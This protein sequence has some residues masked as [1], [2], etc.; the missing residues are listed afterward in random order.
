VTWESRKKIKDR[1]DVFYHDQFI[2]PASR[3]AAAGEEAA[4]F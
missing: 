3:L 4:F 1:R 2:R